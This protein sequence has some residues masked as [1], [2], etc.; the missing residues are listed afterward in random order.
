MKLFFQSLE[1]KPFEIIFVADINKVNIAQG[2]FSSMIRQ[3][4]QDPEKLAVKF[5]GLV[6]E[7]IG[8][9]KFIADRRAAR[10]KQAAFFG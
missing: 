3:G 4:T 8:A 1:I 2:L 10:I 9:E 7:L 5:V 6:E